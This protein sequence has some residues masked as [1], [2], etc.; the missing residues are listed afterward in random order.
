MGTGSPAANWLPRYIA[1]LCLCTLPRN[2]FYVATGFG[3]ILSTGSTPEILELFELLSYRF[4]PDGPPIGRDE[5]S[6]HDVCSNI[7][8]QIYAEFR[9]IFQ[10]SGE[11][12][13]FDS[14]PKGAGALND[15]IC[16]SLEMVIP[17]ETE[18]LPAAN[19]AGRS[20][21]ERMAAEM[22]IAHICI[23]QHR[24][25]E[26]VKRDNQRISHYFD[27]WKIP[28]KISTEPTEPAA[29][30]GLRW[31][32]VE[33]RII[34]QIHRSEEKSKSGSG[35]MFE[36]VVDGGVTD[37]VADGGS[38]RIDLP[39][40]ARYVE[41]RDAESKTMVANCHLM[42]PHDLPE[43]GWKTSVHVTRTRRV[44]LE[45]FLDELAPDEFGNAT[46]R[47]LMKVRV[48][49]N[50]GWMASFGNWTSRVF[51]TYPWTGRSLA[52][53]GAIVLL[54]I[55]VSITFLALS[56][57]T[58]RLRQ[59]LSELNRNSGSSGPGR[60]WQAQTKNESYGRPGIAAPL[61]VEPDAGLQISEMLYDGEHVVAINVKG[62]S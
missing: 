7:H 22:T 11:K 60:R 41:I 19:R 46:A 53:T 42:D 13:S 20:S 1:F 14:I 21:Y 25:L 48:D 49:F 40:A 31:K 6:A 58:A 51:K 30:P 54:V 44:N 16:R 3:R 56:R 33:A 57:E 52:L 35:S 10:T 36:I 24:C 45:F 17:W 50:Q 34:R 12:L 61:P 27:A 4:S 8:Q 37:Y 38:K 59:R 15:D 23:D 9:H 26:E 28:I 32:D 62:I 43:S 39:S 29:E 18:H 55:A 2:A 5:K 47:I